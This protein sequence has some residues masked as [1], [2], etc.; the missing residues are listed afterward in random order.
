MTTSH[1]RSVGLRARA[2][3]LK[4]MLAA[5]MASVLI[6]GCGGDEEPGDGSAAAQTP[7]VAP[8]SAG[9]CPD[10]GT[11]AAQPPALNSTLDCAP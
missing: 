11:D 9:A 2:S 5:T 7:I 6:A 8:P 10:G 1:I 3:T 4:T